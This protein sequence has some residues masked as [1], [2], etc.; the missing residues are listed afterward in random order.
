[1]Y[2]FKDFETGLQCKWK[3]IKLEAFKN[4]CVANPK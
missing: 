3:I 2:I 4:L 1:M